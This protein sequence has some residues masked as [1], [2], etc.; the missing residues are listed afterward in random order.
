MLDVQ[1][2][3]EFG[4]ADRAPASFPGK[5]RRLSFVFALW[6]GGAAFHIPWVVEVSMRRLIVFTLLGLTLA[7]AMGAKPEKPA[8]ARS[9]EPP[10]DSTVL[11]IHGGAGVLTDD[12]M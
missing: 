11:V 8:P 10:A 9:K 6:C 3:T 7:S 5:D 2:L 1:V 12:E 4:Y